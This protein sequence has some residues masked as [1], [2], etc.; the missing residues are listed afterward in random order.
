MRNLPN[1]VKQKPPNNWPATEARPNTELKILTAFGCS[2]LLNNTRTEAS[3]C[4]AK[5]KLQSLKSLAA[6]SIE[7]SGEK[8]QAIEE[9]RK[10]YNQG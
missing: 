10:M 6:I 1:P 5:E 7:I 4:G 8:A 2:V 9:N 3:T